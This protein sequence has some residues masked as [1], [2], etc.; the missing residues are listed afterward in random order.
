LVPEEHHLEDR[1]PNAPRAHYH[2]G[3]LECP[4]SIVMGN[5]DKQED[6]HEEITTNY[7]ESRDVINIYFASKIGD[8]M[9]LNLE[10]KSLIEY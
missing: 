7:V 6:N 10:P 5:H 9:N 8:S 2:I 1:N 4:I 3:R